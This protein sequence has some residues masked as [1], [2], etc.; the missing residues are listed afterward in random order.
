MRFLAILLVL[1]LLLSAAYVEKGSLQF[2]L[3]DSPYDVEGQFFLYI[4]QPLCE[5]CKKL[6]ALFSREDVAAALS[7]YRLYA[8]DLSKSGVAAVDVYVEGQVVYVDHGV[9][10]YFA[11]SG[12]RSFLIPGT[13][14]VL[15]GIKE[16]G[17]VKLLGF[18]TGADMPPGEDL[19]A[20]FVR[21][22]GE[23]SES[24]SAAESGYRVDVLWVFPLAFIMGAVSAFS[25]CVFPVLGI[26]SVT[27]FARR[28]LG[29]VLA[30]LVGSYAA[31]G[32]LVAASG[33]GAASVRPLLAA[34]GGVLLVA[35]GAV[36]LVERLNVKYATA[37]S[38][39]QTSAYKKLSKAGDF[40]VGV[41]LGAVW[42]PCILPYMGFATVLALISLAGDYLLLLTALLMYGGGLALMVY[43]IVRG[44]LKRVKPKRWYEKAVGVLSI[45]IGFYLVASVWI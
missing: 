21:F 1:S 44:L 14:T 15:I 16:N 25:P 30:G 5:E 42:V 11:A 36:L 19:G 38:R 6:E 35:L 31:I 8:L 39:V 45:L 7:G 26:A 17:T 29:R 18:W 20:A 37:M 3:V 12:R 13:P 40:L 43:V 10:K 22:L 9:V 28:S 2:K 27:H 4:Y 24:G 23:V 32:A 33:V 41:S 34:I